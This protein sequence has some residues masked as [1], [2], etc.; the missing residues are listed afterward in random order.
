MGIAS[1]LARDNTLDLASVRASV[2][3]IARSLDLALASISTLLGIEAFRA[4]NLSELPQQ[5]VRLQ[6]SL[7]EETAKSHKWKQF[8]DELETLL[9]NGFGLKQKSVVLSGK[10]A[11]S[12]AKY[13]Y[14]TELLIHC[15]ESAVRVSKRDW[16]E[17]ESRLLTLNGYQPAN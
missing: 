8:A 4:E 9:F 16:E 14:V 17:L 2:R 6:K 12:L 7:P 13:L 1:A 11:K 3:A 5:L 10:D 15:K